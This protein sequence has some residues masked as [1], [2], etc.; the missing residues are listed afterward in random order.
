[1]AFSEKEIEAIKEVMDKNPHAKVFLGS[2]SQR[3]KKKQVKY[4]TSLVIH[5]VDENGIGKGAKVFTDIIM[6]PAIKENLSRPFVRM[7]REVALVT[8]LYMQLEEILLDRDV[9]IHLDVSPNK[10]DGSNVAYGAAVG[11]IKGLIGLDPITKPAS[12]SF[13]ASCVADKYSK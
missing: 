9:E 5:Y 2:D 7:M 13:A 6:E 11:Y 8:E 10:G 3:Q 1:M 4:A 12:M